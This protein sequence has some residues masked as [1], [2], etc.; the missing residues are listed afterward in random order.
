MLA[1]FLSSKLESSSWVTEGWKLSIEAVL[2]LV[3]RLIDDPKAELNLF[4][5]TLEMWWGGV[6]GGELTVFL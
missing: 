5:F 1:Y 6:S 4:S 3:C 2:Y